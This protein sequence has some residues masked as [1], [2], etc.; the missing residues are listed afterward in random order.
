MRMAVVF[1]A[2]FAPRNPKI[3]PFDTLKEMWSTAVNEPKRFTRSFTSMTCSACAPAGSRANPGGQR[4]SENRA[5]I[6]S[7]VPTP[8]TC[9]PKMK[10]MRSVARISS[11]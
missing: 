1:P 4:M 11:G 5:S 10:A 9:P 3:S 6:S 7:G 2:P 8:L